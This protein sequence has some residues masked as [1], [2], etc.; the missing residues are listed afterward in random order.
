[1]ICENCHGTGEVKE[2]NFDDDMDA[3]IHD[4]VNCVFCK[5]TGRTD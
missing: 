2:W 4:I 3:P 5:G 1:M